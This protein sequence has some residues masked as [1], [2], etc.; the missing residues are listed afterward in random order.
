M[1]SSR[2]PTGSCQSPSET[3]Q[4]ARKSPHRERCKLRVAVVV[5]D[6]HV[7]PYESLPQNA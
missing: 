5:E 7:I 4:A 2:Q 1:K 6:V 3:K